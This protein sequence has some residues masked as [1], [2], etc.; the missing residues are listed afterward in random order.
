LNRM[1]RGAVERWTERGLPEYRDAVEAW[2]QANWRQ[3]QAADIL[4]AV[5]EIMESAIKAYMALV[6]GVIPAAWMSEALFTFTYNRLIKR[7]GDP[8]ASTF[9]MGFDNTPIMA[10]KALYELAGWTRNDEALTEYL[11]DTETREIT[12][13][14]GQ[15]SAENGGGWAEWR[16]RFLGYLEE[17]GHTVYTL[18]FSKETPA[19]N[20]APQLETFKLFLRGK[21]VNPQTRQAKAE[22]RRVKATEEINKRHRRI[23]GR[24]FRWALKHAQR[25]APLREDGLAQVGYGYPLLRQMLLELGQRMTRGGVLTSPGDI[26]WLEKRE[27]VD[28][29]ERLERGEALEPLGDR[30]PIRRAEVRAARRWT[31]PRALPQ[32]K[33]LGFNLSERLEG[34]KPKGDVLVGVATSAGRVTGVARV[35]LGPEDFPS[36][37]HGDVLVA[38]ITTPAWTPLFTLASGI[39]TDVGGPLSHGSIVAREY[40]IPAVLGC[41]DAT[42][43]IRSGQRITVDGS[44]GKVYI[45]TWD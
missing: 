30:I 4:D 35:M 22:R 32:I 15:G 40:G 21:G 34:R 31:P 16:Q 26:F 14:L 9:L 7:S 17:Y 13:R 24:L 6:S 45:E 41:G 39:V 36:M 3:M 27:V 10:E 5:D 44:E 20:P 1:M 29:S 11:L 37:R 12:R 28:A 19:D 33:V 23:R 42:K 43:R 25:Y 38:S 18:D 8:D 2:S